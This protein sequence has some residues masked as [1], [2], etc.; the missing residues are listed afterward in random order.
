MRSSPSATLVARVPAQRGVRRRGGCRAPLR[1][2][3]LPRQ[4]SQ[5]VPPN[6]I[7]P[8]GHPLQSLTPEPNTTAPKPADHHHVAKAAHVRPV[9]RASSPLSNQAL[10][11]VLRGGHG[12][13][14]HSWML[15]ILT[16][17]SEPRT[18]PRG[19]PYAPFVDRVEDYVSSREEVEGTLKNFQEMISWV[20]SGA[21]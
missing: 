3:N 21:P 6:F 9:S 20:A 1:L 4:S 8:C 12:R 13:A 10:L 17:C 2:A 14:H 11:P 7:P 19:I 15:L 18:N 5:L 16:D